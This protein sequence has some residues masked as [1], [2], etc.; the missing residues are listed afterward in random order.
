LLAC[1]KRKNKRLAIIEEVANKF[2][3]QI[4]GV[5]KNELLFDKNYYKN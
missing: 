1:C 2:L 4:F 3:E 5:V